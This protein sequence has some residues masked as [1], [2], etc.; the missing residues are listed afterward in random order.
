MEMDK[1]HRPFPVIMKLGTSFARSYVKSPVGNDS[2]PLGANSF[3]L[4][5]KAKD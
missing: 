3:N 4:A 2:S 5:S 1:P